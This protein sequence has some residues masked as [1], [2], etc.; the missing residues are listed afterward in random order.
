M[1]VFT[2]ASMTAPLDEDQVAALGGRPKWGVTPADPMGSTIRRISGTGGDRIVVRFRFTY[3]PSMEVGDRR[4]AAAGRLH[5]RKFADRFPMLKG[6]QMEFRWAG[7]LCL[8]WN[9]VPAFGEVEEGIF[10]ACCQNGLGTAKGTLSGIAAADLALGRDSEAL[11]GLAA[12]KAPRRL[13]PEPLA[14]IGAN[15]VMRWKEWRAAKE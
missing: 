8:S 1:H 7:L 2:Y 11:R 4:I 3:D 5:D 14:W 10:S 15:A 6:V 12:R 13:P 9:G